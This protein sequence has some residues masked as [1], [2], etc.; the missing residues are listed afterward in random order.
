MADIEFIEGL[1]FKPPHENAPEWVIAKGWINVDDLIAWLQPRAGE[2]VNFDVKKAK[3]GKLYAAV[4]NWK[5]EGKRQDK[6][7]PQRGNP[8]PSK[9]QPDSE[10]PDDDIPF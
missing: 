2:K 1:S 4:D 6:A 5:P 10:F 7:E 8:A 3:S 9:P